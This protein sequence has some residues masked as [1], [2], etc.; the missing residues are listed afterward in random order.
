MQ[1]SNVRYTVKEKDEANALTQPSMLSTLHPWQ[2]PVDDENADGTLS[3]ESTWTA[4]N[5]GS[6]FQ[7]DRLDL[8]WPS[9]QTHHI[10]S[11]S[12]DPKEEIHFL[13]NASDDLSSYSKSLIAHNEGYSRH[14]FAER[15]P[16]SCSKSSFEMLTSHKKHYY[17]SPWTLRSKSVAAEELVG[18]SMTADGVSKSSKV[19]L[20]L[21]RISRK[22]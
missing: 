5:E 2:S 20:L 10:S 15:Q 19:R 18:S 12:F 14:D 17:S 9:T 11:S 8:L 22:S 16:S 21:S 4:D 6:S 3:S 7:T 13:G 1:V